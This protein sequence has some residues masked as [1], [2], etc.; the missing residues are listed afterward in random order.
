MA[1]SDALAWALA[2]APGTRPHNLADAYTAGTRRV[3]VDGRVVEYASLTEMERVLTALHDA[4]NPAAR[5]GGASVARVGA[6][7]R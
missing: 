3:A 1:F 6:G 7:W 5:R 2:Q 4:L